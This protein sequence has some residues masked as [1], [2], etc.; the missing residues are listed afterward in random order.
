MTSNITLHDQLMVIIKNNLGRSWED[1]RIPPPV[2][3]FMQAEFI[4]FDPKK[5]HL[6]V[7]FPILENYLN[8][9]GA[10]QG[11][12]IAA[13]VDNTIG[14]LSV[15]VAPPNLTRRLEM[16]YSKPVNIEMEFIL[17]E[18]RMLE[19]VDRSLVFAADVRDPTGK[20]LARAK[21]FHWIINEILM[22]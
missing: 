3:G 10:V 13:A 11:G 8:P 7:R 19:Q 1:V 17:V 4:S 16:T 21:A 14:P 15:L 20:R 9:Y 22:A 6:V 5:K 18:A 2:F 12:M